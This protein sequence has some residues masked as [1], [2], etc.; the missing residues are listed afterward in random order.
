MKEFILQSKKKKKKKHIKRGWS[1][2]SQ[3]I[4]DQKKI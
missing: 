2:I 1:L 4:R 3:E